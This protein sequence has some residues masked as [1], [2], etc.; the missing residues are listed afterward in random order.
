MFWRKASKSKFYFQISLYQNTLNLL[1][2]TRCSRS[3]C[4]YLAKCLV[5]VLWD[6]EISRK[7]RSKIPFFLH[8]MDSFRGRIFVSTPLNY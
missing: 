5:F 7:F 8:N 2:L 4:P 6:F 3:C 1:T